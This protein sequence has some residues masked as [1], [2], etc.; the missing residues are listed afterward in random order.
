MIYNHEF[1]EYLDEIS[2]EVKSEYRIL[3]SIIKKVINFINSKFKL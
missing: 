1:K 2:F 3:N